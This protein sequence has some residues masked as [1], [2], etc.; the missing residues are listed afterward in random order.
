MDARGGVVLISDPQNH[1]PQPGTGSSRTALIL[2]AN[3][4][5]CYSH[6]EDY[7]LVIQGNV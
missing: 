5:T 4:Q 1:P 7:L 6:T 2:K 3:C